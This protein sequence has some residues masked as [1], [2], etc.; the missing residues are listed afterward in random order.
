MEATKG[1]GFFVVEG[2]SLHD[3]IDQIAKGGITAGD[4][5]EEEQE[6]AGININVTTQIKRIVY[7]PEVL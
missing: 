3:R 4:A 6:Q 7:N 1:R 5:N 2:S